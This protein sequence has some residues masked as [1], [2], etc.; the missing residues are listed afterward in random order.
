MRTFV[1]LDVTCFFLRTQAFTP[2]STTTTSTSLSTIHAARIF[3]YAPYSHLCF[4]CAV[5]E[6]GLMMN[7]CFSHECSRFCV[8][9]CAC[10]RIHGFLYVCACLGIHGFLYVC[11][12]LGI[13]GFL[14]VCACLGIHGFLYVCVCLGIHG[15]LYVC[16]CVRKLLNSFLFCDYCSV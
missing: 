16:A 7:E 14:Y 6:E 1:V 12:C 5:A 11:V 10:L 13:H 8:R 2:T 9:V 4:V 3:I 15:F